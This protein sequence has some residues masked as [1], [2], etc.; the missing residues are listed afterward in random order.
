MKLQIRETCDISASGRSLYPFI[1]AIR[2][3]EIA[4]AAQYC[5]NGT[6]HC[7]ILRRDLIAL[8]ELATAHGVAL[9]V[10]ERP[11]LLRR[12]RRYRLRFGIPLGL[13]LCTGVLFY[14]SNTVV[15]IE[16]R[17]NAQVSESVILAVLERSGVTEGVWIPGIDFIRSERTL[18]AA[19]PEIA[20]VGMRH[21]GNRLVVEISEA[22]PNVELLHERTPCNIVSSYDA[23]ITDVTVYSG[24]LTRLI[25]DGVAKGDM[26]V[27]GVIEDEKGHVTYHHSIASIRGIYT[28]E[29]ELT[30]YFTVTETEKTGKTHVSRHLRLFDLRIPLTIGR[31]NFN[32]YTETEADIPFSFLG[33][34]LPFGVI[35]RTY[36]ETLE[37]ITVRTEEETQLALN[38]AIVRYEKNFLSDVEILDRSIT[39]SSDDNGMTCHISYTVEG[40]IGTKSD[41]YVK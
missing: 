17:G 12:L 26:L 5:R 41:I 39:Y 21:T 19:V 31:H 24:Q 22:T 7:R 30:E 4:C 36:T 35:Q 18:R 37:E 28:K 29:A 27:S 16:I 38:A 11:S 9:E 13:L 15:T 6:F 25:G 20:W 8:Q 14:Y 1:N 10:R 32:T 33:H 3:S 40:E 23:Q 34:T 2:Q